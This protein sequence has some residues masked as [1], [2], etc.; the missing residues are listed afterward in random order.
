MQVRPL[1]HPPMEQKVVVKDALGQPLEIGDIIAFPNGADFMFAVVFDFI[2]RG[3][4]A[5]HNI[6]VKVGYPTYKRTWGMS[7][8]NRAR[9]VE[10][11]EVMRKVKKH[12]L[13]LLKVGKVPDSQY[14][15]AKNFPDKIAE[16]VKIALKK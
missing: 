9:Q 8:P 15:W 3:P 14:P 4:L 2:Y 7:G 11:K 1:S 10:I 13:G 16:T 12:P 5:F 6:E